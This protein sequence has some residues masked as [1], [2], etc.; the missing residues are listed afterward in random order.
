MVELEGQRLQL[1]ALFSRSRGRIWSFQNREILTKSRAMHIQM[2]ALM[3]WEGLEGQLR[4][5]GGAN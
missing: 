2:E 5:Y 1:R 4:T 3:S